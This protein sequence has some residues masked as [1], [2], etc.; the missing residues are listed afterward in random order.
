MKYY[1]IPSELALVDFFCAN[2][3][4]RTSASEASNSHEKITPILY[5]VVSKKTMK[6]LLG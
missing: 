4:L 1:G 3:A 5:L 6:G 2:E